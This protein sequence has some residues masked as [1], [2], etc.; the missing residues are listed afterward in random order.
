MGGT[1]GQF[2]A[3]MEMRAL[4]SQKYDMHDFAQLPTDFWTNGLRFPFLSI[5]R[6]FRHGFERRH[7]ARVRR[8]WLERSSLWAAE[9]R[10]HDTV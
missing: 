10:A 1:S 4:G 7:G 6:Y 8:T 3:T 5:S 2:W 9:Q